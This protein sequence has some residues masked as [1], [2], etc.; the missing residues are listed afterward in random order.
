[1]NERIRI[2]C[3]FS[4][5]LPDMQ[6]VRY[7]ERW[8]MK[9]ISCFPDEEMMTTKWKSAS[10]D[11]SESQGK[12]LEIRLRQDCGIHPGA[13]LWVRWCDKI[14]TLSKWSIELSFSEKG[15]AANTD[16]ANESE[17]YDWYRNFIH[18]LNF[19]CSL[20]F[21]LTNVFVYKLCMGEQ[22]YE[23]LKLRKLPVSTRFNLTVT[24]S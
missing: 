2:L 21:H 17:S 23:S 3:Q 13:G 16:W 24:D 9:E 4:I 14:L 7:E 18:D 15:A 11:P 19:F 22:F 6:L 1:M 12:G 20:C 5:M 10:C 8:S